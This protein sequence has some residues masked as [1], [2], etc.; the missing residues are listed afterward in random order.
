MAEM[1]LNLRRWSV[2]IDET[3]VSDQ[4]TVANP[5]LRKVAAVAVLE[6]PYAGNFVENL[7]PLIEQS[8]E[9]GAFIAEKA[10]AAMRPHLAHSYGKGGIVGVS[11][12]QE[13]AN[14]LITTTFAEPLRLALGGGNAWIPSF[15]KRGG[16]GT[17]I[18]IPIAHKD[19]LY[20]RSHYDGMTVM[21]P[22]APMADEIAV[23]ICLA[24]RGRINARV[25][26]LQPHEISSNDGLR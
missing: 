25:G 8:A 17:I 1:K 26:G 20:V 21:L 10:I 9:L 5:P 11:G 7:C 22:D 4:G 12:E 23:V 24:N 18:D 2:V 14:A 3:V 15:T 16:P 6:N 19:A 13:H